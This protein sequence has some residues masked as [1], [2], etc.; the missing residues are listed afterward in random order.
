MKTI[1]ICLLL[2]INIYAQ[3]IW[4]VNRDA[5]GGSYN[6]TSWSNAWRSPSDIVWNSISAGDTIY[7]SGGV[8][9]TTYMP[10]SN[11]GVEIGSNYGPTP[12]WNFTSGNPVVICPAKYSGRT[13]GEWAN[14]IGNVYFATS[15]SNQAQLL[16]VGNITN[17][18]IAGFTFVDRRVNANTNNVNTII[19]LGNGPWG[20]VDSLI[21]FV[22]NHVIGNGTTDMLF[23]SSTKI[24]VDSCILEQLENSLPNNQDLMGISGGGGGHTVSNCVMIL[25]NDNVGT[26]AHRDGLQWSDFGQ[27]SNVRQ[28]TRIFNN[29]L[30]DTKEAGSSWTALIYSDGTVTD[31]DW[32]IYNNIIV[33]LKNATPVGGIVLS[34]PGTGKKANAWILNNTIIMGNDGSQL[35]APLVTGG[36]GEQWD[37]LVI[38]NNLIVMDAPTSTIYNLVYK[39]DH[40]YLMDIDYNGIFEA[41]GFSD[42]IYSGEGFGNHTLA[43]WRDSLNDIHSLIGSATSVSF[44]NKYGINKEDYYTETGRDLGTDLSVEYPFLANDILGNPRSGAWDMGAL[45]FQNGG[46]S[47]NINLLTKLFLEGPFNSNSMNTELSLPNTQ[48]YNTAP[49]NYN[50]SESLSSGSSSGFVDWVLVE[51]RNSSNPTQVVSRRAAILKNDGTLLDTDGNIGVSFSNVQTGS[52]YV[53]VFHRNHLAVMSANP[54]QLSANSQMYDFTTSLNKAYIAYEGNPMTELAPGKFGMYAGNGNGDYGISI[55]DKNQVW[56]PQNGT[57]GYKTGDFNLNGIVDEYD[58][59]FY[60]LNNGKVSQLPNTQ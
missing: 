19:H 29:L 30:I 14:H 32:Y 2:F 7:I 43:Q 6:G 18:K 44:A 23:L 10:L 12:R 20:A 33:S 52:Y 54:V 42:P 46:Q 47:N 28:V 38:K 35:S 53:A 49:W 57:D 34:T 60:N 55:A 4:Y 16:K 21:Y 27:T 59:Y 50:G 15:N 39:Y 17:I 26:G 40:W 36:N 41:N 37:T 58:V 24:T 48:P 1:I 9:S 8:D 3:N 11:N 45:E 5:A 13:T 25:R 22:N 56:T 31:N 51:L